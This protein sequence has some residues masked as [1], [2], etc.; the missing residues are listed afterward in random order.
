MGKIDDQTEPDIDFLFM[1]RHEFPS[2][3][4]FAHLPARPG[5]VIV[6]R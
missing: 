3:L 6:I 5:T 2:F 1:G 4:N